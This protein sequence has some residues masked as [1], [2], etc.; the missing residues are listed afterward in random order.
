[1]VQKKIT[2]DKEKL[3]HINIFHSTYQYIFNLIKNQRLTASLSTD[4]VFLLS[5]L[6][7][8]FKKR[9]DRDVI[10]DEFDTFLDKGWFPKF[11]KSYEIPL[12][13]EYCVTMQLNKEGYYRNLEDSYFKFFSN[14][15][16][17][18][19]VWDCHP[20]NMVKLVN[21][22]KDVISNDIVNKNFNNITEQR[23]FR[24]HRDFLLQ[25]YHHDGKP[26]EVYAWNT[27]QRVIID[28]FPVEDIIL[29]YTQ[30]KFN[31]ELNPERLKQG[32]FYSLFYNLPKDENR[33]NMIITQLYHKY[34]GFVEGHYF[35]I[36]FEGLH[37][38]FGAENRKLL[39]RLLTLIF[40]QKTL[41]HFKERYER[42]CDKNGIPYGKR[43]KPLLNFSL[44][45]K[46]QPITME[47]YPQPIQSK[48]SQTSLS[49]EQLCF[50]VNLLTKTG[51]YTHPLLQ[52]DS[53]DTNKFLN[54]LGVRNKFASN[55]KYKIR[56]NDNIDSLKYF[57]YKLYEGRKVSP[58]T[59]KDVANLF[60]AYSKRTS[61]FMDLQ[62]DSIANKTREQTIKSVNKNVKD[63]I[64]K[65]FSM[66]KKY[67][68]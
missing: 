55:K 17:S 27:M 46:S 1:M 16:R 14:T 22:L 5:F 15:I 7:D 24:L 68:G 62:H 51:N 41:N 13:E 32:L 10:K 31:V 60:M 47:E 23:S 59:W 58:G 65:C 30:W 20:K 19:Y 44:A 39:S 29:P 6:S 28:T 53:N 4:E 8:W 66:A 3:I 33:A 48:K 63:Y 57:I 11:N 25:K 54:F 34:Y 40:E 12:D 18:P 43:L 21:I 49:E 2:L 26:D 38:E 67:K 52:P 36:I 42:Y 35:D 45:A 61:C 64:D 37:G 50:L 56:W 9:S